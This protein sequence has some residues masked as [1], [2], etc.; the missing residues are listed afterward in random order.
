MQT[1]KAHVWLLGGYTWSVF[2]AIAKHLQLAAFGGEDL[3]SADQYLGIVFVLLPKSMA[4]L[5]SDKHSPQHFS[6]LLVGI[7]INT[8]QHRIRCWVRHACQV[9]R[10]A[11][12]T[13]PGWP[14]SFSAFEADPSERL[15]WGVKRDQQYEG[16]HFIWP[17]NAGGFIYVLLPGTLLCCI[18]LGNYYAISCVLRTIRN[19]VVTTD[20]TRGSHEY[21]QQALV[22]HSA[23]VSWLPPTLSSDIFNF[24]WQAGPGEGKEFKNPFNYARR[25]YHT[26]VFHVARW[27]MWLLWLQ[28]FSHS[29]WDSICFHFLKFLSILF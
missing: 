16:W 28:S 7:Q 19:N 9:L 21:K 6:L 14:L 8:P 1:Q 11:I 18:R 26:P 22:L 24:F 15:W 5:A 10:G 23:W 29:A 2:K 20:F 25:G 17:S 4:A 12:K 3:G 27:A 13:E